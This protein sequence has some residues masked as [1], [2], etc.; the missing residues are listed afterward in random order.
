MA[1]RGDCLAVV[2]LSLSSICMKNAGA[3]HYA[4]INRSLVGH[5]KLI[6]RSIERRVALL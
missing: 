3:E 1:S 6:I 2:S 4:G 5:F